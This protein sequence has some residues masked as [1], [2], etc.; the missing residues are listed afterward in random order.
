MIES[1]TLTQIHLFYPALFLFGIIVTF[2]VSRAFKD[3]LDNNKDIHAK[4]KDTEITTGLLSKFPLVS[5][6]FYRKT[7]TEQNAENNQ[8]IHELNKSF[9]VLTEGIDNFNKRFDKIEYLINRLEIAILSKDKE[10]QNDTK[11]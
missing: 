3:K 10:G 9:E 7:N 4:D 2:I 1:N 8:E 5:P 6:D 11:H